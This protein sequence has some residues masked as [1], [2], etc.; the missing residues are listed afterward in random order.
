MAGKTYKT[1]GIVLRKTKL[2]EKDLIVTILDETGSLLRAVAKGGR[3]PGGSYASSLELFSHVDLMLAQGRNL[4]IVTGATFSVDAN[5]MSPG[6]EQAACASVLAE[7]LAT[8]AQED[9]PHERLYA[10]SKAAFAKMPQ[11]S[12]PQAL[13]LTCSALLKTFAYTGFRPSFTKCVVCANPVDLSYVPAGNRFPAGSDMDEESNMGS[14]T[15]DTGIYIAVSPPIASFSVSE[16]GV[17]CESCK[18]PSDTMRIDAAILQWSD[19]LLRSRFED[20]IG[21]D[22][23]PAI[24]FDIMHLVRL[25]TRVHAGKNLKSLDFLLTSGLF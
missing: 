5:R 3:K 19:V 2:G 22:A 14:D 7:L 11:L 6:I 24:F 18:R 13:A 8:I 12:P 1:R 21:F 4:D 25:W 10:M 20:V 17:I 15:G 23:S 16:G 9:L